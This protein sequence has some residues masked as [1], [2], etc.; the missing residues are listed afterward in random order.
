M[1][2]LRRSQLT[3]QLSN[4]G[5]QAEHTDSS[6]NAAARP[7]P[8]EPAPPESDECRPETSGECCPSSTAVR[9]ER[10]G[11]GTWYNYQLKQ[12]WNGIN[13][14]GKEKLELAEVER[15]IRLFSE[16]PTAAIC[17]HHVKR[18]FSAMDTN[19]SGRVSL[20]EFQDFVLTMIKTWFA[21][22]D[23]NDDGVLDQTELMQV[24][25]S[26]CTSAAA[27]LSSACGRQ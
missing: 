22:L 4:H 3:E 1:T 12:L 13:P 26:V 25:S 23:T 27:R 19:R 17:E 15:Y 6:H 10:A 18:I 9:F 24:C 2:R 14:D 7:Q 11:S 16:D 21:A 5:A 20:G 8:A